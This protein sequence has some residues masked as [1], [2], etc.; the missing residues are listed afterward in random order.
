MKI[1]IRDSDVLRSITPSAL[2][3]FALEAGWRRDKEYRKYSNIF[4]GKGLPSIVI[5]NTAS[6]GDY[7]NVVADLIETFADVADQDE[8][9]VFRALSIA[10]R[11]TLNIRAKEIEHQGML[12]ENGLKVIKGA[13][14]MLFAAACSLKDAQEA[15]D[16]QTKQEAQEFI[17]S[18]R[19]KAPEEGSFVVTF[20]MPSL[21][22]AVKRDLFEHYDELMEPTHR[23]V[24]R[25]L[26]NGLAIIRQDLK[27]IS[28]DSVSMI[29][30]L[31]Q[32][33]VSAEFCDALHE[34]VN[35]CPKV[36]IGVIWA[37]TRPLDRVKHEY[38]FEA[39]DASILQKTSL[40]L[41]PT[42][43]EEIDAV[44]LEGI[45]QGLK[46]ERTKSDGIVRFWTLY[47]GENLSVEAKLEKIAY[48]QAIMAHKAKSPVTLEGQLTKLTKQNKLHNARITDVASSDVETESQLDFTT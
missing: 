3:A 40:E 35:A 48:E 32:E 23:R 8:M 6:L 5:P 28:V 11:D 34:V 30:K 46:R 29:K 31:I 1:S 9:S 39:S 37:R 12:L 22:P 43:R 38:R 15:D 16:G 27:N 17:N 19:I 10:D 4:V 25:R 18:V 14:D 20:S 7:A 13:H 33:G 21:A 2:S 42:K 47:E 24:V 44:R 45:I 26:V 41:Q 36:D